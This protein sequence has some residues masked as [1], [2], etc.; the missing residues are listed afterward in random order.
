M[1]SSLATT[2]IAIS[3]A[4]PTRVISFGNSIQSNSSYRTFHIPSASIVI[5]LEDSK[6]VLYYAL[7]HE[8]RTSLPQL[9][10]GFRSGVLQTKA[11]SQSG[12][13]LKETTTSRSAVQEFYD[14]KAVFV[15]GGSGFLGRLVIE[16]LLRSCKGLRHVYMLLREK[17]GKTPEDRFREIFDVPLY[18]QL[19][20]EQ[21]DFLAKISIL[22][23]D[24][25]VPH[26]GLS[27]SHQ[28]ILKEHVSCVFHIGASV[29]FND[30]LRKAVYTNVRCV[31]DL[32]RIAKEMKQ[33][34]SFV[35]VSTAYSQCRFKDLDEIFYEPVITGDKLLQMVELLDD[36]V[37]DDI[38]LKTL[39]ILKLAKE[40]STFEETSLDGDLPLIIL[41]DQD[42]TELMCENMDVIDERDEEIT[43]TVTT[44]LAHNTKEM[45]RH[46]LENAVK[47]M[48]NDLDYDP[49]FDMQEAIASDSE[50]PSDYNE[51][52]QDLADHDENVVVAEN[53][54]TLTDKYTKNVRKGKD[55][56]IEVKRKGDVC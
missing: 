27:K 44:V 35:H 23:G 18:E 49:D 3:S 43:R 14:G 55:E 39:L 51:Y 28:D 56:T 30:K 26:L 38:T 42:V 45:K 54:S 7:L 41:E 53:E 16:K 25:A 34:K 29:R 13:K 6:N 8:N 36:K 5:V 4:K 9:Y 1:G 48:E 10:A 24:L 11:Y 2:T 12:D 50:N 15:T 47:G 20:S 52:G 32:L 22:H 21:P 19:K 37:L 40:N 31:R 17:K 46:N 33:L